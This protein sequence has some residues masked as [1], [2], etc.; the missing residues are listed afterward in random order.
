V[1]SL[2][3]VDQA[4]AAG[5]DVILV[6]NLP[7]EEM[8]AAVRR[9]AGR[10]KIELSGG[11]TLDRIADLAR[12]GADYVSVGALTHSA[13]SVDLSFELEPDPSTHESTRA[14]SSVEA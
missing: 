9:I 12:T 11:V 4:I 3:Q 7:L 13:P 2:D 1:Q 8:R 6:D 5:V 10:A 14:G